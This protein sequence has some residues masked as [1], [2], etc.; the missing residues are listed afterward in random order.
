MKKNRVKQINSLIEI[1][2][3]F[4]KKK[5]IKVSKENTAVVSF[6]D[7]ASFSHILSE[8]LLSDPEETL[9]ILEIALEEMVKIKGIRVRLKDL[10]NELNVRIRDL[11]CK[12]LNKLAIIKGKL[13]QASEVRPQVVSVKFEC[14]ACG[15]I[16]SVLQIE[17]K[18]REPI[19]C[20]CGRKGKFREISKD[21]VDVQ[22]IVVAQGKKGYDEFYGCK[23]EG[24]QLNVF[25]KEDLCDPK[26]KIFDRLGKPVKVTGIIK[27]IPKKGGHGEILTRFDIAM[28]TNSLEFL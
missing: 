19:R 4:F 7:L 22:R 14:P 13:I 25:L 28:E 17:K 27:E 5:K 15:T 26:Y 9:Q 10:P 12:H 3:G 24:E 8:A 18:F 21:M 2:E 16:I 6:S 11:R 23:I 1:A 20:S